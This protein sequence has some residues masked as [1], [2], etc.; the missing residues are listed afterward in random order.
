MNL[1]LFQILFCAAFCCLTMSVAVNAQKRKI[2][3]QKPISTKKIP[4][5]HRPAPTAAK[6]NLSPLELAVYEEINRAR[7]NPPQIV[8]FL[9]EYRAAIKGNVLSLPN[10]MP[11]KMTEGAAVIDE[12]ITDLKRI[13]KLEAYEISEKLTLAARMQLKDLQENSSL[14]HIGKNGSNLKTRLA[15]F[16]KVQ[17]KAGENICFRSTAGRDVVLSFII[18]DNVKS[19][20]HRHNIL[21]PTFKK[22]GIACGIGKNKETLCVT[23]FA[24]GLKDLD[25]AAIVEF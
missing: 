24:E 18:D 23:V 2:P 20:T 12:A 9:E 22:V 3:I 10:K 25:S 13:S 6:I 16:C 14:G 15:H 11:Q 19:R 5:N 8:G 21:S 1:R 7:G 4:S 17:G